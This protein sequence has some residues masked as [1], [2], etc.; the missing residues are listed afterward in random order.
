M[1][2]IYFLE[3]AS[4]RKVKFVE[5][6]DNLYGNEDEAFLENVAKRYFMLFLMSIINGVGNSY[7]EAV[8]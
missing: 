2:R 5:T 8:V 7:V 6:F 1:I 3:E 4:N